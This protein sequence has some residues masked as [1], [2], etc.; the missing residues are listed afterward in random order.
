MSKSVIAALQLE[1]MNQQFIYKS[2]KYPE[3]EWTSPVVDTA[4]EFAIFEGL[5]DKGEVEIKVE[6][7][8]FEV[9]EGEQTFTVK[10]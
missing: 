4:R 1:G 2:E 10:E 7:F 5:N 9:H 3:L 8:P 6:V